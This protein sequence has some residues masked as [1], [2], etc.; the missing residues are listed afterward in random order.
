MSS[1]SLASDSSTTA[2]CIL[3]QLQDDSAFQPLP[4]IS[5]ST[6]LNAGMTSNSNSPLALVVESIK[7]ICVSL[8]VIVKHGKKAAHKNSESLDC[9]FRKASYREQYRKK[10]SRAGQTAKQSRLGAYCYFVAVLAASFN[11]KKLKVRKNVF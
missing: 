8:K 1:A 2:D 4:R 7:K 10:T 9:A 3:S 6:S 11:R 5:N